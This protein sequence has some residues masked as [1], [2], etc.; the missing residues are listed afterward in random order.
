VILV[1][2]K[3]DRSFG[4]LELSVFRYPLTQELRQAAIEEAV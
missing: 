2:N 1:L 4:I 3:L